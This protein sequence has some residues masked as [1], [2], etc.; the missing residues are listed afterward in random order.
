MSI[1]GADD[2]EFEFFINTLADHKNK[3]LKKNESATQRMLDQI[4]SFKLKK[5]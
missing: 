1:V 5:V 3:V 2:N 4:K